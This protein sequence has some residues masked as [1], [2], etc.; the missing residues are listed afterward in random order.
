MTVDPTNGTDAG[1]SAN[2]HG[3]SASAHG[4][5]ASAHGGSASA[6]GGSANVHGGSAN[7]HLAAIADIGRSTAGGYARHVFTGAETT[8]REWFVA[9]AERLGLDIELDRNSNIW[10]WWGPPGDGAVITGSHLDS[11]P[12]GGAFD[13][14]LG[15]ASALDAVQRLQAEGFKPAKPF[16][17]MVF[18]EEE[19][20]RFGVACLG[21]RLMTGAIGADKALALRDV[22]GLTFADAARAAGFAP[23]RMGQDEQA[24]RRIG[25]F[26][27]L[28][29]EQ[30]RGLIDLDRPVGVGSSILAHGR[31]RLSFS[32]TGNH[33][34]TTAIDERR[35][36]MIAAAASVLAARSVAAAGDGVRA[37]VGRLVP[38]PGGTNVIASHVDAWLDVRAG[39]DLV[40]RAAVD[41]I[42]EQAQAAAD[43]EGCEL[44]VREE[45]YG[46]EVF[47]DP[48]LAGRIS[49][50]LGRSMDC[51]VPMLSTGAGHDA[52]ILAAKVPT[53]MIY[54]RNPSGISHAPEEF[55][56]PAD[57][58]AGVGA[59]V[60]VLKDLLR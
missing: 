55:A 2:A 32:G 26:V 46:G 56:E 25:T 33:A 47:F 8:L 48:A 18:A 14:P 15:V 27:E 38:R 49:G 53:A 5:S 50:V 57:V 19:G 21:S 60:D 9:E 22:D 51:T 10:A 7:A 31:W 16:A 28:H 12:G 54:V 1:G 36:P 41:E 59:L 34:G 39:A 35:D 3:G 44:Q 20:S 11:V 42:V 17:L 58:A 13:G 40:T 29:V 43:R 52:G 4:G 45:S 30:G 37:T 23:E 6:H 24:L